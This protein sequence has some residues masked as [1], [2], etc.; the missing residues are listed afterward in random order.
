MKTKLLYQLLFLLIALLPVSA[1]AKTDG[2]AEKQFCTVADDE[3]CLRA[4][5]GNHTK[6]T[7]RLGKTAQLEYAGRNGFWAKVVWKGDT[8]YAPLNSL[9]FNDAVKETLPGWVNLDETHGKWG[10]MGYYFSTDR[11]MEALP[12]FSFLKDMTPADPDLCF[13]ISVWI[14]IITAIAMFFLQGNIRFGNIWFWLFYAAT[15]ILSVCELI[16]LFG[17]PDPLG[18][19]DINNEW[20]PRAWFYVFLT[21]L[22]L[23]QQL[24]LFSTIL[25][26][27]Q[28]DRDF[29]FKAGLCVKILLF[30]VLF[31]LFTVVAYYFD[32]SPHRGIS[33][34]VATTLLLPVI[35]MLYRAIKN[36]DFKP[37]LVLLPFYLIAGAATL[38]MYCLI[39]MAV[40]VLAVIY[41]AIML[42][43][44]NKV[45]GKK[46]NIWYVMDYDTWSAHKN[47]FSDFSFSNPFEKD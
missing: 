19:C 24:R 23:Y 20:W 32:Y 10:S 28:H 44:D 37:L 17:S 16:Y 26:T 40:L 29:D 22:G 2:G 11:I 43:G 45:Y 7:H 3:L 15:M 4:K 8:C 31:F 46:G 38:A 35:L 34:G 14:L 33:L 27:V 18:F 39:G 12:E 47:D 36:L 42:C 9:S 6:I 41:I 13:T 1:T 25:F 30:G 21:G 5:P